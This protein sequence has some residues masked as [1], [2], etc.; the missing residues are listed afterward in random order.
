MVANRVPRDTGIPSTRLRYLEP[1]EHRQDM[2]STELLL[3]DEAWRSL[4]SLRLELA[5]L[6]SRLDIE[7]RRIED[8]RRQITTEMWQDVTMYE[9][10]AD[11]LYGRPS[12]PRRRS[13]SRSP[14]EGEPS[15]SR[16]RMH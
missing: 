3:L 8:H 13:R 1:L 15:S 2:R 4:D 6:C 11:A 7:E 5:T 16:R 9:A 10:M 12:A 14:A